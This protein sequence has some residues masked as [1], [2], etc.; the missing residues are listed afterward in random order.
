[1]G[2]PKFDL[3]PDGD[4]RAFVFFNGHQTGAMWM[5][6]R[7]CCYQHTNRDLMLTKDHLEIL[8]AVMRGVETLGFGGEKA[9]AA[10]A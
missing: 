8:V 1:M 9:Q 7:G 4:D 10:G 2:L 5:T 6:D 3:R